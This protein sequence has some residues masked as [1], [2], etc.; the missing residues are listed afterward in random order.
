ASLKGTA[1]PLCLTGQRPLERP[2]LRGQHLDEHCTILRAQLADGQ[3]RRTGIEPR[4]PALSAQLRHAGRVVANLLGRRRLRSRGRALQLQPPDAV[5]GFGGCSG[6]LIG[7]AAGVRLQI[8]KALVLA[9]QSGKQRQ[10]RHV[11]VNIREVAGMVLVAVFQAGDLRQQQVTER[12]RAAPWAAGSNP[13]RQ[14]AAQ[15]AAG[16]FA[17]IDKQAVFHPPGRAAAETCW[18]REAIAASVACWK[19]ATTSPRRLALATAVPLATKVAMISRPSSLPSVQSSVTCTVG[20]AF[21][22]PE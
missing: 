22:P 2:R 4:L 9:F 13:V 12:P 14:L 6:Q 10:Q 21:P 11:L 18:D 7:A 15:S 3:Q 5:R 8:K 19:A 1:S 20:G 17:P 16:D